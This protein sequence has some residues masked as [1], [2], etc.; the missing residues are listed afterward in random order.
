M[1]D[2]GPYPP[3][4]GNPD[5]GAWQ[6]G[7]GHPPGGGGPTGPAG[8][9]GQ[10][11]SG[12]APGQSWPP[13]GGQPGAWTPQQPPPQQAGGYGQ[14]GP[15]QGQYGGQPPQ[16]PWGAPPPPN[17]PDRSKRLLF[18]LI[19]TAV[20][21]ALIAGVVWVVRNN[22][23]SADPTPSIS[24]TSGPG[25]QTTQP[26]VPT[27]KASDAVV[28]Y[29]RALG[30]GDA[31]TALSLAASAPVGDTAFLTNGVL[32]KSTAGKL[33]NVSVPEVTDP[34]ATSVAATYTLAGKPVSA[35]FEVTRVGDQFRLSKVTS[36]TDLSRLRL[37]GAPVSLAGVPVTASTVS[38]FPGIYPVTATNRNLSYG[39]VQ[40]SVLSL[41]G[42]TVGSAKLSISSTGKSAIMK[43][44]KAKYAWC[45]KQKTVRPSGCGFGVRVPSGVKLQTGTIR[46][47]TRSG[48]NVGAAKPKLTTPTLAE[49]R[50]RATVHF[51]AR[52]ARI[53]GRYWYKDI[54]LTGFQARLSGSKVT[55][56]YY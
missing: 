12:Q 31:T 38:L 20:V 32:A 35:T 11:G 18:G 39:S 10:P 21:L 36:D 4:S 47:S 27:P 43:A 25:Q 28:A 3:G 8:G 50:M 16:Q 17:P 14:Y 52:D 23:N 53:S 29:L 40:V 49:A 30:T 22:N 6:G 33:A 48:G 24:A 44:A 13:A 34:D 19:G 7:A 1:S 46:W 45:L 56:T 55:V 9:W 51:Y 41:A 54:K 26:Q 37:S 2:N 15:S 5:P 42:Q